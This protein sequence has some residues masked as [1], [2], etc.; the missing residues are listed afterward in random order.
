[1]RRDL[2]V[3]GMHCASC[4]QAVA[5]ALRAVDGVR[6][7]SV[8]LLAET[9][10]VDQEEDLPVDRL[11]KAVSDAG[12][13]ASPL[14]DGRRIDVAI[15]GMTCAGCAGSVERALAAVDGVRSVAI[16]LA[17]ERASLFVEPSVTNDALD[18]AV[19]AAGYGLGRTLSS[20]ATADDDRLALDERRAREAARRMK[21]AW[22]V[23]AP[24]VAWMI[25]EMLFGPVSYT[26]LTL[27]TN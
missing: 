12:Y 9:A 7:A 10:A 15:E 19:R 3:E 13:A 1:M 23:A 25:P 5:R 8:D 27:P 20:S 11:M 24:I 16:N 26:H 17:T 14:P 2:K 6:D 22:A 4:A 18:E 21:V